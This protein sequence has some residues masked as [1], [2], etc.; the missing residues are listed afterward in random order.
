MAYKT[1]NQSIKRIDTLDKVTG[2]AIYPGDR[3]QERELWMK[4]LFARRPHARVVSIDIAEAEALPGVALILTAKDVPVNEYGLQIPD[5]PVLCGPGSTK[6]GGDVVR[7]VGDHVALVIAETEKIAAKARDLI[8]V[9][10]EDLPIVDDPVAAMSE[11]AVQLHPDTPRNIAFHKRIRK[12]D[13]E[14][15]WADCD[16][17][18]E[19]VYD[20]PYQ[21]HA[22]L[23]PEAGTAY[24]D[25]EGRITV[26]CA[27]Q[28]TWEDQQQIAHAL[29]LPPEQECGWCTMPSV[30]R[31]ADVRI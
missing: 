24:I 13:V 8:R 2:A 29:N 7:F 18:I 23:Q 22:Y 12:G 30:A 11:A 16:V 28:W 10:Y 5:Q 26:H 9:T 15:V 1:I 14:S 3:Q 31:L 21:E 19:G 17:I 4:V 27:G 20:T 6:N 25:D